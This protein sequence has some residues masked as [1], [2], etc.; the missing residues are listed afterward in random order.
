MFNVTENM[1]FSLNKSSTHTLP[2]QN[3]MRVQVIFLEKFARKICGNINYRYIV[4]AKRATVWNYQWFMVYGS[5]F[6]V[7]LNFWLVVARVS[8]GD[9]CFGSW[10]LVVASGGSCVVLDSIVHRSGFFYMEQF[11][12]PWTSVHSVVHPCKRTE[13]NTFLF[14]LIHFSACQYPI[15]FTYR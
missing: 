15:K 13:V 5:W 7:F 14:P 1:L 10:W 8:P 4:N 9:Q 2:L 11:S 12:V 6:M 3:A